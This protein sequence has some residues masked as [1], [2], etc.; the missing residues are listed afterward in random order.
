MSQP[1]RLE[2]AAPI[3]RVTVL[4]DRAMVERRATLPARSGQVRL[5]VPGVAPVLV[6]KSLR[7]QAHGARVLDARCVRIPAPWRSGQ[8]GPSDAAQAATAAVEAA[9]LQLELAR[10]EIEVLR[11][12][13]NAARELGQA[14]W[15]DAALCAARGLPPILD[16][17]ALAARD[18][19][20]IE[21]TAE[22]AAAGQQVRRHESALADAQRA[23]TL[24]QQRTGEDSAQLELDCVLDG[25]TETA[26]LVIEYLVPAAAWRPAHRARLQDAQVHWEH[27]AC[28]WQRTGEDWAEV[29]LVFSAER[30]SLGVEPPA[31]VDDEL[32]VRG[33]SSTVVVQARE[34]TIESAG[35]GGGDSPPMVMGIDDGGLGLLLPALGRC[36]VASD[37]RPH[38][39]PLGTFTSEA[40]VDLLA[41]PLLSLQCHVRARFTNRGALPIL[42]GPVELCRRSG[43]VGRGEIGF[44]AAGERTTLGF[45]EESELR[46]HREVRQEVEDGSLL[47]GGTVKTTRV[48]IR[49][50]NLG[51]S[52]RQLV[53]Q[54]RV[55]VSELEQ[56]TVTV[57]P[58]ESFRLE[59]DPQRRR[60]EVLPPQITARTI[61][62][63][64]LVTWQ[65][66]LPPRGH[67]VVALEYRVKTA[68]GVAS[69]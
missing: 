65:V 30:P 38:R 15:A 10:T 52:D 3:A 68:R 58:P 22:L 20:L 49:L 59:K 54:D 8:R 60:G 66:P 46:A 53:V 37:G 41:I 11:D 42:P 69:V 67:A 19:E 4:E 2:L 51:G 32:R 43:V 27:A 63:H 23:A 55:P 47:S 12:R 45:A 48:I 62:E 16:D 25:A 17:E 61:D 9:R 29:E 64:G 5:V 21:L 13:L 34:Q 31:V 26:T 44:V 7:A 50:S 56:V 18:R 36:T 33:K 6:D 24:A 57:S 14:E 1:T 28:V 40:E 39:V 35:E